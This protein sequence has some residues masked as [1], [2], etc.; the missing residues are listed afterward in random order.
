MFFRQSVFVT[1]ARIMGLERFR[2]LPELKGA[3]LETGVQIRPQQMTAPLM[4]GTAGRIQFLAIR[5]QLINT[6]QDEHAGRRLVMAL[7]HISPHSISD[8]SLP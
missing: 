8:Y 6:G 3:S 1:V 2:N 7:V 5:H 4:K